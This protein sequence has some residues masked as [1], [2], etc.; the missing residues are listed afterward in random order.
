[1]MGQDALVLKIG[2][3]KYCNLIF[4]LETPIPKAIIFE[5]ET[6]NGIEPVPWLYLPMT[7][8]KHV[9]LSHEIDELNTIKTDAVFIPE[10]NCM[11]PS[12]A[13]KVQMKRVEQ[14][15]KCVSLKMLWIGV[16]TKERRGEIGNI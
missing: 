5:G 14:Q 16:D 8:D 7:P 2:S 15:Q 13:L 6:D 9:W 11:I 4:S 3:S 10:I 1:M 12:G